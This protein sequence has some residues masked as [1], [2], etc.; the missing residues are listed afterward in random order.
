MRPV[1]AV[2][3]NYFRGFYNPRRQRGHSSSDDA[4]ARYRDRDDDGSETLF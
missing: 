3:Q 1:Q 4:T 2:K